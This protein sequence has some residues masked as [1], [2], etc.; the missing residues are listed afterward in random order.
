MGRAFKFVVL[1][2]GNAAGYAAYE[3]VRRGIGSGELCI[4]SEEPVS[5]KQLGACLCFVMVT[6]FLLACL[7]LF[8][9]PFVASNI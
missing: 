7:Y 4:I 6:Y 3:F 2:G 8:A 1:G 9:P 5:L